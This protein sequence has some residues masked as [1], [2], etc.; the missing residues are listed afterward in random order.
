MIKQLFQIGFLLL[1]LIFLPLKVQSEPTENYGKIKWAI[2]DNKKSTLVAQGEKVLNNRDFEMI[3]VTPQQYS[4]R[5]LLSSPFYFA[6]SET[7]R[8]KT[9]TKSGFGLTAGRIDQKLFSWEW[10]TIDRPGHAV[11]LQEKSELNFTT[12]RT[13]FGTEF[14]RIDFPVDVSLRSFNRSE[15]LPLNPEF[16][17][18][19]L[20][21]SWVRW[22]EVARGQ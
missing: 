11:K 9:T 15:L 17:I 16:R 10:F 5:I 19:I 4:K 20:K 13:S 6:L 7:G 2:Y 1:A 3:K 22:P 12:R 14:D 21:G 8:D 18:N